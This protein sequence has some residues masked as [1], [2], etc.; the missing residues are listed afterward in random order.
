MRGLPQDFAA[1][2]K[3]RYAGQRCAILANGPS[4]PSAEALAR[5]DCTVIGTNRSYER[6]A[7]DIHVIVDKK[8][9]AKLRRTL[10]RDTPRAVLRLSNHPC[11]G[12]L[13]PERIFWEYGRGTTYSL[14]LT[15]GWVICCVA[16]A[17]L[18][19]ATYL[20]FEEIIFCGLDL[21]GE[22]RF[23]KGGLSFKIPYR[24]QIGFFVINKP[25]LDK[26]GVRVINTTVDSAERVFEKVPF[27]EVFR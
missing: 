21:Q 16:P 14:D 25:I 4:L 17:A 2:W 23:Y 13:S 19:A 24:V 5:I 20:G 27:D 3:N 7:S 15:E 8:L 6:R 26:L 1:K 9:T 10:K 22:K 11:P 18:Q 12:C